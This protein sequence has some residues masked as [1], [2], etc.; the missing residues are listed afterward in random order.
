MYLQKYERCLRDSEKLNENETKK[1]KEKIVDWG[2]RSCDAKGAAAKEGGLGFGCCAARK[3]NTEKEGGIWTR[4]VAEHQKCR[5]LGACRG[6][7]LR[8]P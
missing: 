6:A 2:E 7:P 5:A 4:L 8:S 1:R 3:S